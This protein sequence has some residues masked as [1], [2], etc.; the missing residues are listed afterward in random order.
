[1]LLGLIDPD[2]NAVVPQ[3][4]PRFAGSFELTSQGDMQQIYVR[5]LGQNDESLRVLNVSQSVDDT[6]WVSDADDTLYATDGANDR[7]VVVRGP[8]DHNEVLVNATPCDANSAPSTCPGPGFPPDYLAQLNLWTGQVTALE[9][10][11]LGLQP[12]GLLVVS[13]DSSR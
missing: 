6:A 5:H 2:S 13:D 3:D 10:T 4:S 7:V 1:V 8:F 9:V 12:A 11:G